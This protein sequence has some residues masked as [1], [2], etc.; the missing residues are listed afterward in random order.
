ML[1][2]RD[3]VPACPDDSEQSGRQ[4]IG[5]LLDFLSMDDTQVTPVRATGA[6]MPNQRPPRRHYLHGQGTVVLL[7]RHTV[8][9]INLNTNSSIRQGG[10]VSAGVGLNSGSGAS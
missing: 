8:T 9:L 3:S 4:R 5:D 2:I 1:S 6:I 10:R 7:R